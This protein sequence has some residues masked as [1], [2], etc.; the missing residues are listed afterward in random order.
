MKYIIVRDDYGNWFIIPKQKHIR[1]IEL[2][3]DERYQFMTMNPEWATHIDSPINI[4]FE[5]WN[6]NN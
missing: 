1:W 4:E 6:F 5:N 2:C 3:D